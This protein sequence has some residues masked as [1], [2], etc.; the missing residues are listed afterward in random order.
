MKKTVTYK[1]TGHLVP[2][3]ISQ[4]SPRQL[5]AYQFGSTIL[6]FACHSCSQNALMLL[7]AETIPKIQ[8]SAWGNEALRLGESY[9]D[10]ENNILFVPKISLDNAGELAVCI[11]HAVAHIKA[12]I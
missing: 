4:L 9:Y 11:L 3:N 6:H 2:M 7:V 1:T 10:T 8:S 12:G 5:V